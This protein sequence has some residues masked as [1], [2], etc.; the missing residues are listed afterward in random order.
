MAISRRSR[1]F[2][3]CTATKTQKIDTLQIQY[4]NRHV[5]II[6]QFRKKCN[7]TEEATNMINWWLHFLEVNHSAKVYAQRT[8]QKSHFTFWTKFGLSPKFGV[9]ERLIQKVKSPNVSRR[10]VVCSCHSSQFVSSRFLRLVIN[11]TNWVCCAK[12]CSA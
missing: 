9:N 5:K 3:I 10:L 2:D 11:S 8:N 1:E 6:E 12:H 7:S 4:I